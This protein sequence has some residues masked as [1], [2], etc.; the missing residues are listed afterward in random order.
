MRAGR[1]HVLTAH[2]SNRMPI[3]ATATPAGFG[4]RCWISASRRPY[5]VPRSGVTEAPRLSASRSAPLLGST[6]STAQLWRSPNEEVCSPSGTGRG[7]GID[8]DG[9]RDDRDAGGELGAMRQRTVL[10]AV[11]QGLLAAGR[12]ADT[13]ELRSRAVVGPERERVPAAGRRA[14]GRIT[15]GRSWGLTRLGLIARLLSEPSRLASS[16]G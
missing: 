13:A 9:G 6:R 5:T 10:G 16:P 3:C 8:A 11:Q 1:C 7:D 2:S 4:T 14:A 15:S 12:R